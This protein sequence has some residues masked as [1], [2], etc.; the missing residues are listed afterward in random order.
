MRKSINMN[1]VAVEISKQEGGHINCNIADIKEVCKLLLR[2]LAK[3]Q[4]FANV[5]RLVDRYK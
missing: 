3:E 4:D 1:R 2:R 5:L